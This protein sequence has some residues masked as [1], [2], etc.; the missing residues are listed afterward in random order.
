M[1]KEQETGS[2]LMIKIK[3]RSVCFNDYGKGELPILFLHGFPFDKSSWQLQ[4]EA[5]KETNRVLAYD[6]RGFGKS[7]NGAEK[8][9]IRLFAD[10]LIQF[11]DALGIKKAIVCGLSMGGYI[12]LNAIFRYANRFEAIVL[13][14]T[15]CISDSKETKEKRIATILQIKENGL[16]SF[17]QAFTK[18]VFCQ[19]TLDKKK[20]LVEKI[21][22][23]ILSNSF[24]SI[25]E[26]L[27]ALT[28]RKEMC[29]TLNL[30]TVPAMIIC[31]KED[32]VTVPAQSELLHQ[33]IAGSTYHVIKKAGHLSNL[34]QPEEFNK[35][36]IQFISVV[37]K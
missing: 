3:G 25:T 10:D 17:A 23:V 34:E 19:E 7:E 33:S 29:S 15:Q 2:D 37:N 20:E 4:L 22:N 26:T 1:K 31:G 24:D 35:L 30:I 14:D 27:G 21:H 16:K 28:Q 36:L 13:C 5:L 32:I 9:S 6:I 8:P 18:S 11:M 12:L